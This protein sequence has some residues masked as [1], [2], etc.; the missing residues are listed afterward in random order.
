M[1]RIETDYS[2][3]PV[4]WAI[5]LVAKEGREAELEQALVSFAQRSLED[6]GATG[7]HLMRPSP[8]SAS[9]EF[10]IHRSFRSLKHSHDFYESDLFKQYQ[11]D[12]AGLVDGDAVIRPL[13]GFEAFFR[14]GKHVPP[15]WKM[16]FVTWLGVFPSVVLFSR[17][18]GPALSSLPQVAATAI[19][20]MLVVVALA[21]VIMP[22]LTRAFRPWL[23]RRVEEVYRGVP[24]PSH[25]T[26]RD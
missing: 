12:T 9:R 2:N 25:A 24:L 10:R 13:H 3:D 6:R 20:T 14:E 1:S 11:A 4:H 19:I 7:V 22:L 17:L 23:H 18:V 15:R 21:W 5:S 16:A 26:I 8:G